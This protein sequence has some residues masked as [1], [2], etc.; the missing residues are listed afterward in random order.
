VHGA[1]VRFITDADPGW[2]PYEPD[3]RTTQV[4]GTGGTSTQQLPDAA[5]LASW[6]GIR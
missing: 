5:R 1:W 4:F 2:A 3:S 6:E